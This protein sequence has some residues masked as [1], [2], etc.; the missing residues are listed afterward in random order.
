MSSLRVGTMLTFFYCAWLFFNEIVLSKGSMS[1]WI[2]GWGEW[3]AISKWMSE[4]NKKKTGK[5][6]SLKSYHHVVVTEYW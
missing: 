4:W 1:E 2:N 6:N 5:I 3:M